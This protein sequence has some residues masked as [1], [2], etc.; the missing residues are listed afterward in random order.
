MKTPIRVHIKI[1]T[2]MSRMGC[3][4]NDF[5]KIFNKCLESKH[6]KLEGIYSHLA[7]SDNKNIKFNQKQINLF[8]SIIL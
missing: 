2:G 8:E 5:K 1:D 4:V 7:N 3:D 6:I